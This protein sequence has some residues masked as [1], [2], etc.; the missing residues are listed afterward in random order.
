MNQKQVQHLT[1]A[2]PSRP[3]FFCLPTKI[4]KEST[5]W[6]GPFKSPTVDP[7]CQTQAVSPTAQRF[8]SLIQYQCCHVS[9][10]NI[11]EENEVRTGPW[12]TI[13]TQNIPA[14]PQRT[15]ESIGPVKA[16]IL[17]PLRSCVVNWSKWKLLRRLSAEGEEWKKC[18]SDVWHRGTR[19][20]SE[21]NSAKRK[22]P[23][24]SLTFKFKFICRAFQQPGSSK[25]FTS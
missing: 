8:T 15:G 20:D 9:E 25:F 13:M 23:A 1:D 17:I 22:T 18:P 7:P 4:H 11:H 5:E 6:A 3:H 12:N 10:K 21:G 16:Q 24:V 14:N 19:S 2:H